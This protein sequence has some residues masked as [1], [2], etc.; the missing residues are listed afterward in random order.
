MRRP[1]EYFTSGS[2][3][4][5]HILRVMKT[6]QELESRQ[7]F[8]G[9]L[10]MAAAYHDIGYAGALIVTGYHPIDGALVARRDGLDPQITDAVLHHSGAWAL[11]QR[12]RPEL[13]RHYGPDCRMMR[14]ALSRALTFCDTHSGPLGER[15]TLAERMGE[16]RIRHAANTD[17]LAALDDS[18][19]DF[20]TIEAEFLPLLA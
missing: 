19:K 18:Q 20:Q 11:A 9:R 1:E 3:R 6:A 2:S 16:I 17:L 10:V 13:M 12:S 14:T 4:G 15:F 7:P 5:A 8:G